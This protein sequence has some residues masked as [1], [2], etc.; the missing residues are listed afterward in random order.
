MP[1]L[2]Y[3]CCAESVDTMAQSTASLLCNH[4]EAIPEHPDDEE[5]KIV[6]QK[7]AQ[8]NASILAPHE[9]ESNNTWS[10]EFFPSENTCI[11]C[12][13]SLG[14]LEHIP[15]SN[16]SAFLLTRVKMLPAKA[17]IKRCP[18]TKCLARHSYHSWKEGLEHS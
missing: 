7:I 16:S 4:T 1:L 2:L 3:I 9:K 18:N 5:L 10:L 12:G 14:G 17:W 15:G 11:L 13:T 6:M 8:K